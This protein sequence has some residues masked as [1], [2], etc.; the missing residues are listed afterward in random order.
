MKKQFIRLSGSLLLIGLVIFSCAKKKSDG[1]TPTYGSTGNPYPNNP[2]VTG[3]STLTNPA[4]EN[5][6]MNVGGNGWSNPS[7]GSTNSLTLKGYNGTIDVT[8]AFTFSTSTVPIHSGTYAISSSGGLNTCQLTI[9]NAP[10]QPAG[11]VWY[12]KSGTVVV[13]TS[14]TSISASFNGVVCTQA[15]FNFPTVTANGFLGCTQ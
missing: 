12:G 8:L 7:C 11:T 9:N 2:T 6:S 15:S 1:I 4:T 14:S 10:N 13:N 3:T 5:T